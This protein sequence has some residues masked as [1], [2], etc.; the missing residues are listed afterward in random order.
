MG[1]LASALGNG[2]SQLFKGWGKGI[3]NAVDN[4]LL[5]AEARKAI[6]DG[7]RSKFKPKIDLARAA[8]NKRA[9]NITELDKKLT[10][11]KEG[12]KAAQDKWR[13]NRD[14]ELAAAKSQRQTDID[15]YEA[16]LKRYN[17]ALG[18][19]NASR[20]SIV[21]QLYDFERNYDRNKTLFTDVTTGRTYVFNPKTGKYISPSAYSKGLS[22]KEKKAFDNN[23]GNYEQRLFDYKSGNLINPFDDVDRYLYKGQNHTFDDYLRIREGQNATLLRDADNKVTQAD[24]ALTTWQKN[25][26]KPKAWDNSTDLQPFKQNFESKY[27]SIPDEYNFNGQTYKDAIALDKAYQ[28]ALKHEE[29]L[30]N[31]ASKLAS[32]H[33]SDQKTEIARRIQEAKDIKKAKLALGTLGAGAGAGALYAGARAMYGSDSTDNVDN[34]DTTNYG[35]PDPDFNVEKEGQALLN[36]EQQSDTASINTGFDPDK[37]DALAS[38]AYAKGVED[39]NSIESSGDSGNNIAASTGGHTIDDGLFELLKAMQ[40]PHKAN[41]VADYIYSRHGDDPEVQRLGWR[42]WLNKY[43][44]DSLRSRMNL[45][46]SGYNGMHVSG[47]L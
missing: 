47:G 26:L 10:Q 43:Y 42:A 24:N 16:E 32:K 3:G 14:T 35:E 17:D 13:Q 30:Q 40:D 39:G 8:E 18:N 20:K 12:L 29:A 37:A 36:N 11:S 15:T 22:K 27:G 46:P 19:A 6:S 4:F 5:D 1:G 21:D 28:D 2:F 31:S 45:D 41:A 44:G 34:T 23:I 9:A 33:I 7:V 25:N 38:A